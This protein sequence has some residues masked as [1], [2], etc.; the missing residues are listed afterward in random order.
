MFNRTTITSEKALSQITN[1]SLTRIS[2]N[3]YPSKKTK[4]NP[5][6]TRQSNLK[7]KFKMPKMMMKILRKAKKKTDAIQNFTLM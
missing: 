4:V 6:Y 5:P 7:L 3:R 2:Q 1:K